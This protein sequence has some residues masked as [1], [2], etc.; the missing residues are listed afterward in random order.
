MTSAQVIQLLLIG[1]AVIAGLCTWQLSVDR[2][3][4][5][6]DHVVLFSAG[7]VAYWLMPIIVGSIG[8]LRETS[9]MRAWFAMYDEVPQA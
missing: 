7:F 5:R 3:K 8:Y 6:V 1:N 4:M 9:E 2:G